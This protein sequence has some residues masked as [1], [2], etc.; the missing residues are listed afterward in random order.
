MSIL[1]LDDASGLTEN[2][3]QRWGCNHRSRRAWGGEMVCPGRL[4]PPLLCGSQAETGSL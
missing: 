4:S 3:V 2:R 1:P